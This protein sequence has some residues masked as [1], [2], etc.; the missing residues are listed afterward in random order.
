M[1]KILLPFR[2]MS[3]EDISKIHICRKRP[4]TEILREAFCRFFREHFF[5]SAAFALFI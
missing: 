4:L 2:K 3:A 1:K 5:Y